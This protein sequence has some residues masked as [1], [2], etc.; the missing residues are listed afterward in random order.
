MRLQAT[1]RAGTPA[2]RIAAWL[3]RR[4]GGQTIAVHGRLYDR[5]QL[6]AL[7]ATRAE[8]LVGVLTYLVEGDS[9]EIVSCD[10]DPAGLGVGRALVEAVIALA[11]QRSVRQVWCTTTNDNLPA[12]GFW[13][14]LGFQLV[15]LRQ[16]AVIDARRLKPTIPEQGHRGLDV[17]DELDLA[18]ALDQDPNAAGAH[19]PGLGQRRPMTFGYDGDDGLGDRLLAAALIGAKTATSSLAVEYVSGEPLPRVGEILDLRDHRG[20]WQGTVE[21]TRVGIMPLADVGDEVARD[22][23]EGFADAAAWR[24]AHME[25]W[26]RVSDMIRAELADPTWRLRDSEPVVVEWF[27]LMAPHLTPG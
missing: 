15:A 27:R 8:V 5:A 4:W 10:A 1:I 14:A 22:E 23:G 24:Q 25:F 16:G 21:T 18:I 11:R 13:Q 2:D 7:V 20:R 12:L 6:P 26:H 19:R 17:R 9:T 3:S